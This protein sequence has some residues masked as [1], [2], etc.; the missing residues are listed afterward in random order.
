MLG[1]L[2]FNNKY[3]V[4]FEKVSHGHIKKD[5]ELIYY[6]FIGYDNHLYISKEF[7]VKAGDALAHDIPKYVKNKIVAVN[8]KLDKNKRPLEGTW[9]F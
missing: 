9:Y 1:E 3:N 4:V 8:K 5:G 6:F 7:P 2:N